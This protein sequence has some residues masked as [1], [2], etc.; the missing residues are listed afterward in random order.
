[1]PACAGGSTRCRATLEGKWIEWLRGWSV[2]AAAARLL[3]GERSAA[4]GA[5]WGVCP[6]GA[7]CYWSPMLFNTISSSD[8]LQGDDGP[9]WLTHGGHVARYATLAAV[10]M[11][12]E[13]RGAGPERASGGTGGAPRVRGESNRV[14]WIH[15]SKQTKHL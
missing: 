8:G 6:C 11:T 13:R 5:W 1:M 2:G 4:D 14:R 3:V 7:A 15:R 10:S 12:P 9:Q